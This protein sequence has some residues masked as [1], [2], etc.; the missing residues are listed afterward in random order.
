MAAPVRAHGLAAQY[1]RQAVHLT[2]D[3][4]EEKPW[5]NR[6]NGTAAWMRQ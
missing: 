3:N 5:T 6:Y 4:K 1:K 2:H